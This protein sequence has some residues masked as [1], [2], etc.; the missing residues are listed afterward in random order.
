[1]A[2]TVARAGGFASFEQTSRSLAIVSRHSDFG[3][4]RVDEFGDE[5]SYCIA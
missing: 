3:N 5:F 1:M 4:N 2:A